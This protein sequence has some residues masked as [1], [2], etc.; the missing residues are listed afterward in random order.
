MSATWMQLRYC[1]YPKD[2]FMGVLPASQ[3]GSVAILPSTFIPSAPSNRVVAMVSSASSDSNAS[4]VN[5][6]GSTD[7]ITY[8]GNTTSSSRFV[9][10]N[11]DLSA[12]IV[13]MVAHIFRSFNAKL[14]SHLVRIVFTGE[15]NY[16]LPTL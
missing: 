11:S 10:I 13:S 8:S 16:F 5:P 1:N 2:M 9:N 6:S 15:L 4:L 14:G 3:Y 7:V 12:N